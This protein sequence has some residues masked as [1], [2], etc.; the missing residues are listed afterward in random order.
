MHKHIVQW[1]QP[2]LISRRVKL[3][4]LNHILS[5]FCC[6]YQRLSNVGSCPA[7]EPLKLSTPLYMSYRHKR[8][9]S[10]KENGQKWI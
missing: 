3:S 4:K 10:L 1:D 7:T 2:R 5:R 8:R 6:L 9:E